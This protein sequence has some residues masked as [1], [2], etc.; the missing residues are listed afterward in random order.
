MK[1]NHK[2]RINV[3][4]RDGQ[5]DEVLRSGIRRFPRRLLSL[6]F[7]GEVSVLVLTP[8]KSVSSVEI[9]ELPAGEVTP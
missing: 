5:N 2:V 9:H 6:L 8:G 4:Q 7:G 3:A 1:L